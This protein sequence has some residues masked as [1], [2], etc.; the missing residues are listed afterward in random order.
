MLQVY[1]LSVLFNILTGYLFAFSGDETER[2]GLSFHLNNE[3]VRLVIGIFS[4]L[5]GLL[6]ILSPVG[7][8]VPVVGDIVPALANA[9]AG[10]ILIFEFYRNRSTVDSMAAERI[11]EIIE[12]NR[13]LTGFICLAAGILHF[14]FYS[15]FFL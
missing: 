8:N 15:V 4:L 1:F 14:I 2:E 6:K 12:K 10:F 5:T 7:G 11:G 13:K 9:A 3:T